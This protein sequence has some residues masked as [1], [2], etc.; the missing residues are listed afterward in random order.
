MENHSNFN[1]NE[2][3]LI[4]GIG[5]IASMRTLG[6]SL[7]I[8]FLS[9]YA[10]E[11]PYTTEAL[12]GIAVGIFGIS[13]TLLQIPMGRLSDRCGRK[14]IAIL[15]LS[16]FFIGSIL[17]GLS[18]N[19]YHL[20]FARFITGSGAFSG[21]TMAWLTDGID[22]N[23]RTS[24]LTYVAL[25]IG[26]AVIIGFT[27]SPI[28]AG[29]IGIPHLFYLC[30]A[31]ISIS[32][33]Y[34][35]LFMNNQGYDVNYNFHIRIRKDSLSS[36][37]RNRDL[38]RLNLLG[39]IGS[40][41]HISIFFTL[42]ILIKDKMEITQMWKLYVPISIIGTSFMFYFGQKADEIGIIRVAI[43]AILFTIIGSIIP[44]FFNSLFSYILSFIIFYSGHSI[45]SPVLPAA[46]SKHPNTQLNG[47]VMGILNSSQ[48]MGFSAGGFLSGFMLNFDHRYLFIILLIF[49]IVSLYSMF[50]YN[51]F[52]EA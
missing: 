21:V 29:K 15:G 26:I 2:K 27:T 44:I 25:G 48:F 28:I 40:L 10:T 17:S 52:R 1:I 4:F 41:V 46:V 45:L 39:F 35:L 34:I 18:K 30:A 11:I 3:K 20:I 51:D 32:I 47:T 50:R 16:I 36:I 23:R 14:Q 5:F 43:T 12:S 31:L 8:P 24:A 9:I 33:I 38:I 7:I 37:L 42:P 19:I 6:V 22:K 13:Q 49:L